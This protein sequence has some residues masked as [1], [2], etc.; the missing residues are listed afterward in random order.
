MQGVIQARDVLLHPVLICRE[1]GAGCFLRCVGAV[2]SRRRCTFL[3]LVV[4]R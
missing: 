4:G 3:D 1:F 2:L